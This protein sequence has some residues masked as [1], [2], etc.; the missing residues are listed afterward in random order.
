MFKDSK[1]LKI[2]LLSIVFTACCFCLIS[3]AK[4][5]DNTEKVSDYLDNAAK[6]YKQGNYEKTIENYSL[7]IELEPNNNELYFDRGLILSEAGY[8]EKAIENFN[9]VL[10][11]TNPDNDFA[12]FNRGIAEYELG[13]YEKALDDFNHTIRLVP[14]DA[15]A[16]YNRAL[17]KYKL[18]DVKGALEDAQISKSYYKQLKEME[19]YKEVDNFIKT[20]DTSGV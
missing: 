8:F 16:F 15:K 9:K 3:R 19:Y 4:N 10:E 2:L 17:T 5:F 18:N 14:G 20:I 6:Y 12:I 7:A 11:L 13:L 1:F